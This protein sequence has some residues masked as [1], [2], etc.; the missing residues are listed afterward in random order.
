MFGMDVVRDRAILALLGGVI[1][2]G[3]GWRAFDKF[4]NAIF[5]VDVA[6]VDAQ[7]AFSRS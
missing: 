4:A 6:I 5:P 2:F 3:R 1:E 7:F